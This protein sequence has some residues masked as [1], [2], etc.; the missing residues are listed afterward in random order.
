MFTAPP[1][2]PYGLYDS[3]TTSNLPSDKANAVYADGAYAASPTE[4]PSHTRLWIDVNTSDPRAAVLDVEPGDATPSQAGQWAAE[5]DKVS[6]QP[7]I[8]YTMLSDWAAVKAAVPAGTPVQFWIADPTGTPHLVP[9]SSATQWY[10][11][12]SVDISETAPGFGQGSGHGTGDDSDREH[13][14]TP[15]R[16]ASHRSTA[17]PVVSPLIRQLASTIFGVGVIKSG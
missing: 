9:G 8:V 16:T 14:H 11:G 12:S 17:L 2:A 3:T 6:S 4:V 10:W 13:A 7:A 1:P 5:H 15:A